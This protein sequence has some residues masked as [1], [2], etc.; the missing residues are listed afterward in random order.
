MISVYNYEDPLKYI[1]DYISYKREDSDDFSLKKWSQQIGFSNHVALVETLKGKKKLTSLLVDTMIDKI[2]LDKS[3]YPFFLTLVAKNRCST[4]LEENL[5]DLFITELSPKNQEEFSVKRFANSD[6]FIHWIFTTILALAELK[7]FD[8]TSSNIRKS[9]RE[10]L[11]T[12]IIQAALD[13]LIENGLIEITQENKAIIKQ[14]QITSFNDIKDSSVKN[15]FSQMC[16]LSKRAIDF[17]LDEREFQSFSLSITK[18]KISLAKDLIRKCRNN[19]TALN[20]S[21]GEEVYQMN[22]FFFP[23]TK[24]EEK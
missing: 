1:Q 15:Y 14:T 8:M 2:G 23:L 9:L 13:N 20:S 17:P 6:L 4:D 22:M 16:E 21:E 19:L 10:D 24:V 18:D 12:E 3:E 7:D 5:Y 11:P